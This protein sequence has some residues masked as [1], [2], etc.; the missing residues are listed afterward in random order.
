MAEHESERI[1]EMLAVPF[2]KVLNHD[3]PAIWMCRTFAVLG[4][5]FGTVAVVALPFG[6]IRFHAGSMPGDFDV[7]V[8]RT[9]AHSSSMDAVWLLVAGLSGAG[10]GAIL[11]VGSVG[12]LSFKSWSRVV[13]LIWGVA[14]LGLSLAGSFFYFRWLVPARRVHAAQARGVIDALTNFGG[15]GVGTALA[16]AMLIVLT[17]PSVRELFQRSE[18]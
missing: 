3:T 17:R 15:W 16:I 10:L 13:L 11:L 12:A 2:E 7:G 8:Y 9:P 5:V 6:I 4:V 18:P 14:S 1:V